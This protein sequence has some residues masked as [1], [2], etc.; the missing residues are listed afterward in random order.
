MQHLPTIYVK[1]FGGSLS[2]LGW[3]IQYTT[4]Y[5][6]VTATTGETSPDNMRFFNSEKLR[7]NKEMEFGFVISHLNPLHQHWCVWYVIFPHFVR[8]CDTYTF[9][10]NRAE[11]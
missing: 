7:K 5:I 1:C 10:N 9:T 4:R 11:W 6:V 3:N 8:S 2:S